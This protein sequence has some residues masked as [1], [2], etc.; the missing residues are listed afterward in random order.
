M[1]CK[2][3]CE[4]KKIK[5]GDELFKP[6]VS[7]GSKL[8]K[9]T[10]GINKSTALER[11][12][13]SPDRF[14]RA[15]K[16]KQATLNFLLRREVLRGTTPYYSTEIENLRKEIEDMRKLTQ[17]NKQ[18]HAKLE[19]YVR[20]YPGGMIPNNALTPPAIDMETQTEPP[21]QMVDQGSGGGVNPVTADVDKGE[22]E[23]EPEE[24]M[25]TPEEEGTPP[26]EEEESEASEPTDWDA[27]TFD[28]AYD[29]IK[30]RAKKA[31]Q[32][33]KVIDEIWMAG[34]YDRFGVF[35]KDEIEEKWDDLPALYQTA[36]QPPEYDMEAL[37]EA[38]LN[39]LEQYVR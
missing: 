3:G 38:R 14:G 35:S 26:P 12:G 27:E 2:Y 16:E 17:L 15:I 39:Y 37:R 31:E 13:Y 30:Y 20:S 23:P 24:E 21:P 32:R 34:A 22:A 33:G 1:P 10:P 4:S 6:L 11:L 19:E 5:V 18:S 8:T 28:K 7:Y 36:Q 25:P 29:I 9:Y